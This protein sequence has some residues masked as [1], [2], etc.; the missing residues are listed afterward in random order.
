MFRGLLFYKNRKIFR[1]SS[2]DVS[3]YHD[4]RSQTEKKSPKLRPSEDT[5]APKQ[6][7]TPK[8]LMW[9]GGVKAKG[10]Q[11]SFERRTQA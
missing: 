2:M 6:Y 11:V 9:K 5:V 1:V 7:S 3:Q 8:F 10:E 4:S